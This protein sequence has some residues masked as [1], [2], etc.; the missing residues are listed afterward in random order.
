MGGLRPSVLSHNSTDQGLGGFS[1][2]DPAALWKILQRPIL[3][4]FS[5]LT[6]TYLQVLFVVYAIVFADGIPAS[7][8][9]ALVTYVVY[10]A[11]C[12]FVSP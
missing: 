8:D 9:S 3:L 1:V 12:G 6:F 4:S 10:F 7:Q 5:L 11:L 2:G